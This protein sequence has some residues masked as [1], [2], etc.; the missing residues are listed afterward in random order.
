ARRQAGDDE[1]PARDDTQRGRRTTGR[2]EGWTSRHA[3]H[4]NRS[5]RRA[6]NFGRG[7]VAYNA[8]VTVWRRP[9]QLLPTFAERPWGVHDLGPLL[10]NPTPAAK[11]GEAWFTA[12]GTPTQI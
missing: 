12:P 2:I 3:A 1:A 9:F 10:V 6:C 4:P 11:I 7:A 8:P 5:A